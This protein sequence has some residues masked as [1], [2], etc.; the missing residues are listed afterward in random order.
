M[1]KS[2]LQHITLSEIEDIILEDTLSK[3]GFEFHYFID[4]YD[5]GKYSFPFGLLAEENYDRRG[6][7]SIELVTDEQIAYHYLFDLRSEKLL[8]SDEHIIELNDFIGKIRRVERFGLE[9]VDAF[10][11]QAD[12]FE[13]VVQQKNIWQFVRWE[14]EN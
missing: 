8:L 4:N 12:Y 13:N 7:K 9:V 10:T 2:L 1:I 5:I 14:K 6:D 3:E 11:E